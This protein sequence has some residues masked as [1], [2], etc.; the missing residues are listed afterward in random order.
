MDSILRQLVAANRVGGGWLIGPDQFLEHLDRIRPRLFPIQDGPAIPWSVIEPFDFQC[1]R[2]HGGQTLERI[3]ERGGLSVLEAIAVLQAREWD[4]DFQMLPLVIECQ[5]PARKV[6]A[7][8]ILHGIVA[9]RLK[10]TPPSAPI[11]L[12]ELVGI[13][14]WIE[15][16][17]DM[18]AD[19]S[20]VADPAIIARRDIYAGIL[21]RIVELKEGA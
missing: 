15:K 14:Q 5:K 17:F 16:T 19:R 3:A 2:N 9:S 18:G 10:A 7:I 6:E 11:A 20:Q 4:R 12:N 13:C 8:Q 1:R 21:A